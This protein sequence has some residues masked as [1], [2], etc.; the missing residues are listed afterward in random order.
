MIS[1]KDITADFQ[2]LGNR[3]SKFVIETKDIDVKGAKIPLDIAFDY[4]VI[5]IHEQEEK[6][7]GFIEFI[8]VIKAKVKNATLF[9]F[10]LNM[11]GAFAGN[12]KKITIDAFKEMVELNGIITLSQLSRAYIL[13]VSALSGINPPI[14]L[15]MINVMK[16]RE[17]KTKNQ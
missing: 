4:N 14:R 17:Q 15:P 1:S 5:N 8:V 7:I 13:S 10:N 2:F 12:T 9:K 16:L 11:E 3:V 6:F